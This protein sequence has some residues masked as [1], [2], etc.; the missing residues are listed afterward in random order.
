MKQVVAVTPYFKDWNVRFANYL[1]AFEISVVNESQMDL[2]TNH[3]LADVPPEMV[4][5]LA[6]LIDVKEADGVVVPG[7]N[8]A[9]IDAIELIE[10]VSQK[11]SG[12]CK[13]SL[14]MVRPKIGR[15]R[16]KG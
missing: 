2:D 10:K 12:D 8:W 13:P 6:R 4:Y 11:A 9:A 5:K 3:K 14:I 15:L 7:T 1:K 16:A